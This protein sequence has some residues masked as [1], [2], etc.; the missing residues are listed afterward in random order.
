M[1]FAAKARNVKYIIVGNCVIAWKKIQHSRALR[2]V[3]IIFFPV[4][5]YEYGSQY[6]DYSYN[7]KT[8]ETTILLKRNTGWYWA[9]QVNADY[10]FICV[11]C[12]SSC[13]LNARR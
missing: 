6:N 9:D 1:R 10:R 5:V 11:L 3:H 12:I 2:I 8:V 4:P 13:A 7:V